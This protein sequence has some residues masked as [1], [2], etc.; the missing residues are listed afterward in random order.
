MS[1]KLKEFI[2]FLGDVALLYLSLFLAISIRHNQIIDS[3]IWANHWPIFSI[4]FLVWIMVF[5]ISG[6]YSLNNLRNEIKFFVSCARVILINFILAIVFFYI[7]PQ[8]QITP[9]TI[10]VLTSGLFFIL[11]IIWRRLIQQSVS[12]KT[13]QKNVLVIGDNQEIRELICSLQKNPQFGYSIKAILSD[14]YSSFDLDI[15]KY[16]NFSEIKSIIKRHNISVIVF[17][18]K[19]KN[20]N[21]LT[22]NLYEN[23]ATKIQFLSLSRFYEAI[24]LKIPLD[25]IDQMWFLDNLAEA[26][27]RTYDAIKRLADIIISIVGI[28]F[29]V[30]ISPLIIIIILLTSGR[31]VFFSQTRSGQSGQSFK[32]IKF[33]TMIPDAEKNGP[34]WAQKNDPRVTKFGKFLRKTRL[35]EIP[36]LWNI[37]KGEMSFVGPRPERPEFVQELEKEIPFYQERFLVKPGLTGWAQINYPYGATTKDALKKL[38][39][40]LYYIKNRSLILDITIILKTIKTVLT[41]VGR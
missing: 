34:Q 9:K 3:Q 12:S 21:N 37:I 35:D 7:W 1:Q 41:A 39:Y 18:N 25:A 11:F 24:T 17:D 2:F 33:R 36:Q 26:D 23:I 16:Q 14:G 31:P 8:N 32:A 22:K 27:K 28:L 19:I 38:Q 6:L 15:P 29:S 20:S 4:V 5:Y 13:F 10:L 30:V 40:D